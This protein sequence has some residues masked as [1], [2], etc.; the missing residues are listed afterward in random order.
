MNSCSDKCDDWHTVNPDLIA[1]HY[2]FIP[3]NLREGESCYYCSRCGWR[4]PKNPGGYFI[5]NQCPTC[6][7]RLN[8]AAFSDSPPVDLPQKKYNRLDYPY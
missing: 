4:H 1:K 3:T 2:P 5:V 7:S 6:L 8:I